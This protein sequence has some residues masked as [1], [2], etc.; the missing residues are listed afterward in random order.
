V[1]LYGK[2]LTDTVHNKATPAR[3]GAVIYLE[4]F[5]GTM[6][7]ERTGEEVLRSAQ[8]E[9]FILAHPLRWEM[10]KVAEVD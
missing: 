8:D 5:S 1:P 3:D 7:D 10:F 9:A 4:P 6:L 2:L